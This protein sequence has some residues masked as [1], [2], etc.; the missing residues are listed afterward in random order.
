MVLGPGGEG[1]ENVIKSSL[2]PALEWETSPNAGSFYTKRFLFC[3]VYA[4]GGQTKLNLVSFIFSQM[5]SFI[6]TLKDLS[7]LRYANI[8]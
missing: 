3:L 1:G 4:R 8:L 7:T 2:M 6:E 5:C